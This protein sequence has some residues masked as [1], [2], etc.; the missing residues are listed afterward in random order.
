MDWGRPLLPAA[1]FV[2]CVH[3]IPADPPRGMAA[4]GMD[5]PSARRHAPRSRSFVSSVT[6]R[7][8]CM[9]ATCPST[10]S[11]YLDTVSHV[12]RSSLAFLT[13]IPVP[14]NLAFPPLSCAIT[15]RVP[16]T[17]W[18]QK[19]KS[20]KIQYPCCP[21][22]VSQRLSATPLRSERIRTPDHPHATR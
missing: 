7:S 21:M 2:P 1:A 5:G 17:V 8:C 13:L 10:P 20:K 9:L 4:F 12:K 6:I 16:P 22:R 15:S 19:A 14:G 3:Q 11:G 18:K